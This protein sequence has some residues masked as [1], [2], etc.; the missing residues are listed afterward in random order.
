MNKYAN[1]LIV[2]DEKIVAWDIKERLEGLGY[3]IAARAISGEAA[4]VSLA[5]TKPDL[6]LMDIQLPGQLNGIE[7]AKIIYDQFNIPVVYLTAHS[8]E[9]TLQAATATNPFGYLLKPFQSRELHS[10][11]QIALR[12]HEREML[13][14]TLQQWLAN[15]LNSLGD[16]TITTD[17][18]GCITF[19]N[20]IAEALTGWTQDEAL[21]ERVNLVLPLLN[22]KTREA[23][24]LPVFKA[25]ELNQRISLVETCLLRSKLGAEIYVQDITAPILTAEGK[26]IGSV[27]TLQDITQQ[28]IG[29]LDLSQHNQDLEQFQLNLISQISDKTSQFEKLTAY[30]QILVQL[31]DE[32]T[33]PKT[34]NQRLSWILKQLSDILKYDYAWIAMYNQDQTSAT[35]L[36]EYCSEDQLDLRQ[37][38]LIVDKT[39]DITAFPDFYQFLFLGSSWIDPP[40]SMLPTNYTNLLKPDSHLLICPLF[41][42]QVAGRPP[43]LFGEVGIMAKGNPPWENSVQ[44]KLITQIV[45]YAASLS[46]QAELSAIMQAQ[47]IDFE[48]LNYLKEDFISSV[49]HELKTPLDNM[50]RAIK[51]IHN[52]IQTLDPLA[53]GSSQFHQDQN[54]VKQRLMTYLQSLE[55]DWQLEYDFVNDLLH[56]NASAMAIEPMHLSLFEVQPC[57]AEVM[58]EFSEQLLRFNLIFTSDFQP[59]KTMLYSHRSSVKRIVKELINNAIKYTPPNCQICLISTST[60][61]KI[62]LRVINTGITIPEAELESIFKPFYRIPRSNPW[63]YCGTGLGLALIRKLAD[64]LGGT[65]EAKSDHNVTT[66]VLKLPNLIGET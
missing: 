19:M 15:T 29:Q 30:M 35:I 47:K 10:T 8:D 34:A 6:V 50:N 46:R 62:E 21:G 60:K 20:P 1:I 16:A 12:R 39:I 14:S 45:S 27:I 55:A 61:E 13:A 33:V 38:P 59:K 43:V 54:Q 64:R 49:S 51:I 18:Q 2:E 22:L 9:K 66:F 41:I 4:I 48:S 7:T 31:L 26:I 56:F 65:I 24:D 37:P 40:R 63:D 53:S 25:M 32:K 36:H 17:R 5:Q 52:L 23:L 58:A 11:I 44:V 3:Q 57:C 42:K 28:E